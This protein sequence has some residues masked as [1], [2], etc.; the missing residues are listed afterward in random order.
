MAIKLGD[1]DVD[2]PG[3]AKVYL[4]DQLVYPVPYLEI[5]PETIWLIPW[6]TND[7]MSNVDWTIL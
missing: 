4:G 2:L 7:V 5:E 3:M 1:K 6:A